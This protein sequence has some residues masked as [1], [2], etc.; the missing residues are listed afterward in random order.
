LAVLGEKAMDQWRDIDAKNKKD[1]VVYQAVLATQTKD[2]N[3]SDS[4]ASEE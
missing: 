2:D 1:L 4:E 3:P